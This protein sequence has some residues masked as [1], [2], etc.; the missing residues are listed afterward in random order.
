[1]LTVV[2]LVLGAELIAQ[3]GRPADIAFNVRMIDP[4]FS[5]SVA[6]AD[7]NRDGRL[8]ILSAEYWYEAPAPVASGPAAANWT[9]HKIREIPFNG[10]YI[11]NFSD[12][13]VDVDG[14]G[15]T[16]IVQIAYFAR[17]I[18]WLKNPGKSKGPWV[19]T[20]I[21]AVGPTEFAFLVD[22]NND[23]RALEILPQFTGAG[24]A[25]LSW[26]E[27]ASS[28]GADTGARSGQRRWVKH[29]VSSQSHGHGIGVG[30]VNGDKRN[31]IITPA[32]WLEAPADVRAEGEW[33]L[34][35]TDWAAV[36]FD[37]AQPFRRITTEEA[38][39]LGFVAETAPGTFDLRDGAAR[40]PD[41]TVMVNE[42]S[43]SP[44]GKPL[45][46]PPEYAFMHVIDVNKDGRSDIVTT[47]AHSYGV[48]WFE[49]LGDGG[50]TRRMIDT[51]WANAHSSALADL[52]GDG[53][54]DLV[55]A[56]RYFG[57]SGNDPSEREPMGI[58]WYQF[59]PGPKSQIEWI[60]HIV[61]YG[62]RA[63]GGLQMVVEDLDGDGDRDVIT[64][65]KTGLF[66]SEN[67]TKSPNSRGRRGSG[68]QTRVR[69]RAGVN[70][71]GAVRLRGPG[72]GWGQ[73]GVKRGSDLGRRTAIRRGQTGQRSDRWTAVKLG[74][75]R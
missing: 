30:D 67:L 50:W 46:R 74:A 23:G 5:E 36:R 18:V 49:Q 13:P 40:T 15:Y 19:E 24:K 48:L 45:A 31:D 65:G 47:M 3:A 64:A 4:G 22:L 20:E 38:M 1:M 21:D 8:D 54:A 53:Q 9:K 52:N 37:P 7:F 75:S 70:H 28:T 58:Y 33:T 69:P 56:K 61:D 68:G 35:K 11:D 39:K 43:V 59:R 62:G 16:D 2:L 71:A 34:H 29:V 27:L 73:T 63:G 66:L 41:G 12:L 60:R 17:R 25:P 44:T 6:V 42:S 51:T 72:A 26:Y 55:A 10:S 14:D 32:G 57:R